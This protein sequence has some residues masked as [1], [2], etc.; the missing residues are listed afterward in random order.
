MTTKYTQITPAGMVA[1]PMSQGYAVVP[2]RPDWIA[3]T[4]PINP[5]DATYAGVIEVRNPRD[6]SKDY[7]ANHYVVFLDNTNC[8][9]DSFN[10]IMDVIC[11]IDPDFKK[12]RN[13]IFNPEYSDQHNHCIATMSNMGAWLTAPQIGLFLL[14]AV[15]ASSYIADNYPYGCAVIVDDTAQGRTL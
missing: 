8:S 11:T 7:N 6:G 4:E 10:K 12:I 15:T 5:L 2:D 9:I 13:D 1:I 14:D 3:I